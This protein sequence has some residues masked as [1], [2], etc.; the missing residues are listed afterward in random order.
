MN[1]YI[2]QVKSRSTK[3]YAEALKNGLAQNLRP[4]LAPI[5][6][7]TSSAQNRKSKAT[8]R[9]WT[10]VG[11]QKPNRE[12]PRTSPNT[13]ATTGIRK[14]KSY[15]STLHSN[16]KAKTLPPDKKHPR[17]QPERPVAR[18]MNTCNTEEPQRVEGH[19]LELECDKTFYA[20]LANC[21][22]SQDVSNTLKRFLGFDNQGKV[23]LKIQKLEKVLYQHDWM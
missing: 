5:R 11:G 20:F 13:E 12:G 19:S 16:C 10:L 7:F 3:S 21:K 17:R 2:S 23:K 6:N 1:T 8:E 9:P 15:P 14:A 18:K 4:A 22:I